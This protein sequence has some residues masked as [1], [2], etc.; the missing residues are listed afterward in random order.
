MGRQR[1]APTRLRSHKTPG[2]GGV[3]A[4]AAAAAVRTV[5]QLS[6]FAT[7]SSLWA[8]Y[9]RELPG[10]DHSPR[11]YEERS[12]TTWRSNAKQ[13]WSEIRCLLGVVEKRAVE[14]G[15]A[16]GA[17]MG[18]EVAA[19]LLDAEWAERMQQKAIKGGGSMATYYKQLR[20]LQSS[21]HAASA[22]T[23]AELLQQRQQHQQQ[24]QPSG[25]AGVDVAPP[26]PLTALADAAGAGDTGA[27][28]GH[29]ADAVAPSAT[30]AAAAATALP[31]RRGRNQQREQQQQPLRHGNSKATASG[32]KRRQQ[33]QQQQP[34]QQQARQGAKRRKQPALD[35]GNA[36]K[37][38]VAFG[39]VRP[40][41]DSTAAA[42][43]TAA[44]GDGDGS[45]AAATAA[46]AN[47]RASTR[48]VGRACNPPPA[49]PTTP[50][51][52][53]QMRKAALHNPVLTGSMG[54]VTLYCSIGGPNAPHSEPVLPARADAAA[55][56]DPMDVDADV[57]HQ[58]MSRR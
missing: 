25:G 14:A 12:I 23:A 17:V 57:R 20:L 34:Q 3:P 52:V 21:N 55:E 56:E 4:A 13:R 49:T 5:P 33:Q 28:V 30:A 44:V 22:E 40:R 54:S 19:T 58:K 45:A 47:H 38:R 48:S 10:D 37:M 50:A 8:W 51:E 31:T 41:A 36:A 39:N 29:A 27:G 26:S 2:S 7:F 11:W 32:Q 9:N 53:E 43:T 46:E 42:A 18:Q 35:P 16:R 6:T 24:Q 1:Q 15:A